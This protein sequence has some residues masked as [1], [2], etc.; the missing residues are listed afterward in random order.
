MFAYPMCDA[1]VKDNIPN[2]GTPPSFEPFSLPSPPQDQ[3]TPK[4]TFNTP[5][6]TS[7]HPLEIHSWAKLAK[8]WPYH[9][10]RVHLLE[11][12]LFPKGQGTRKCSHHKDTISKRPLLCLSYTPHTDNLPTTFYYVVHICYFLKSSPRPRGGKR[13]R[14][15]N[16]LLV[17]A[18]KQTAQLPTITGKSFASHRNSNTTSQSSFS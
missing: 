15:G 18:R 12:I 4:T 13:L 6:T 14:Q 7:T 11:W 16:I 10:E 2:D 8:P 5:Q 1:A 17:Q 9:W 3:P